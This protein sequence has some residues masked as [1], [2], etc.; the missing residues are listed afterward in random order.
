MNKDVTQY[1]EGIKQDWQVHICSQLRRTITKSVSDA[2]ELLQWSK[3]HYKKNNQYLCV[4]ATAKD[5]VSFTL[6]NASSVKA[7]N[8]FFEPGNSTE[9]KTIR[10]R[11][12]QPVDYVFLSKLLQ[13]AAKG[14]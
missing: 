1:I 6:F 10:I 9:R 12:E 5:W 2:E 13:Q 14:L 3:P 11:K 4:F 8:N 7:P